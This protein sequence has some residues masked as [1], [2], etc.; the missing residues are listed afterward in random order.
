MDLGNGSL[1]IVIPVYNEVDNIQ[2]LVERL[3][4]ALAGWPGALEILFVD[5][6]STDRT[7]DLLK[8]AQRSDFFPAWDMT[9]KLVLPSRE[10]VNARLR[11]VVDG[12]SNLPPQ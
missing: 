1:T 5:D 3:G 8:Q 11:A 10:A 9:N 7:L 4:A 6:G 2:P 12:R